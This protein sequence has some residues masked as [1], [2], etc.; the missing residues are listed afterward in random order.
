MKNE[1]GRRVKG[2]VTEVKGSTTNQIKALIALKEEEE[3]QLIK[4]GCVSR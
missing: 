2:P 4:I 1:C 3:D